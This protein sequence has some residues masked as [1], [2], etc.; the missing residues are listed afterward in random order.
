MRVNNHLLPLNS[1][2]PQGRVISTAR[3]CGGGGG[4]GGG[5][6]FVGPGAVLASHRSAGS[7]RCDNRDCSGVVAALV[8]T[9]HLERMPPRACMHVCI[10]S[11]VWHVYGMCTA[12]VCTQVDMLNL[13]RT[14]LILGSGWSTFSEVIACFIT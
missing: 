9:L 6:G 13:A 1:R 8:D 11:C 14:G 2:L 3:T 7:E 12:R 5:G 10:A 4:G